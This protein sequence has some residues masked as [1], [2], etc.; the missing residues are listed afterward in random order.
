MIE[1]QN[2]TK[3]YP[4][5]GGE[6]TILDRI[7]LL[8]KPGE[9]LG[10]LGRNGAGKSTLVRLL[11]GSERP[12]SGKI[13]RNMKMSWPI[14]LGDAFHNHLTGYDNMRLIC[15]IYD[16]PFEDKVDFVKE[17]SELGIYLR[18]DIIKYSSGMR[19]RLAF[20]ISMIIEFDCYLIDE[21]S[22]VG[23]SRFHAKCNYE[24]FE[25][26]ADRGK[27]IVSHDPNFI[28]EHCQDA[29]VLVDG[30][31]HHFD[32]VDEGLAFYGEHMAQG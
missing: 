16:V 9:K 29:V 6:R 31:M 14:A 32:T 24:L 3:C 7:N 18:E 4:I 26:R 12:T 20:A 8:I 1:L 10:V 27:V 21:V 23:D 5:H 19:A 22:A 30:K 15:R 2:V 25:K 28:R 13:I 11:S 17:F